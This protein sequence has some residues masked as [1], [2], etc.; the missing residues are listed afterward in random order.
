VGLDPGEI[1]T[2]LS[3]TC[4]GCLSKEDCLDCGSELFLGWFVLRLASV[5]VSGSRAGGRSRFSG[6]ALA[7]S[8]SGSETVSR[9]ETI[10]VLFL[11]SISAVVS[12]VLKDP[13]TAKDCESVFST[14]GMR[15]TAQSAVVLEFSWKDLRSVGDCWVESV[16]LL[17]V[18]LVKILHT[19]RVCSA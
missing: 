11:V 18:W 3:V 15:R 13:T 5:R 7:D 8:M 4:P 1:N 10:L 12:A 9:Q 16:F 17:S 2:F 14:G 6:R 19:K